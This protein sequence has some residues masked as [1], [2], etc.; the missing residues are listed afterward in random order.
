MAYTRAALSGACCTSCAH[1]GTCA[2][3][4]SSVADYEIAGVPAWGV[5]AAAAALVL[6]MRRR[7]RG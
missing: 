3:K 4:P 2:G 7:R 1:G 5:V 6:L